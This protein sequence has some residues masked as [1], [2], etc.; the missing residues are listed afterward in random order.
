MSVSAV[1]AAS[2]TNAA[3]AASSAASS[4]IK[5]TSDQFMA[6]LLAQ[7]KNQ[8]PMEPLKDSEMMTQMT[9]LNSLQELQSIKSQMEQLSSSTSASFAASLLG[10][11]VKAVLSDGTKVEGSVDGTDFTDGLYTLTIKGTSIPLSSIVEVT[12]PQAAAAAVTAAALPAE[13]Q[14]P[15]GDPVTGVAAP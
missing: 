7:L 10:K 6:I 11:H 5:Q 13:T 3:S 1:N 8:D 15:A 12:N 14:S 4:A 2:S 9:Q